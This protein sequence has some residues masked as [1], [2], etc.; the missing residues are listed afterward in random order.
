MGWLGEYVT[1]R[2]TV[3]VL[4]AAVGPLNDTAPVMSGTVRISQHFWAKCVGPSRFKTGSLP[5]FSAEK[6]LAS[7]GF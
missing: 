1:A 5:N 2:F 3:N 6:A 4:A 7:Q